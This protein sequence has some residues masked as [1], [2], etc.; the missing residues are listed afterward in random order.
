M[1]TTTL[2]LTLCAALA[3]SHPL[4]KRDPGCL[5]RGIPWSACLVLD[6]LNIKFIGVNTRHVH[7]K[8]MH[9]WFI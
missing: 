3:M 2:A 1:R 5:K 7:V 8:D 4:R 9:A 6:Q